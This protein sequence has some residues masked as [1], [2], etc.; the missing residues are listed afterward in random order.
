MIP[1]YQGSSRN[2]DFIPLVL[3]E[4]SVRMLADTASDYQDYQAEIAYMAGQLKSVHDDM[5]LVQIWDTLA[6]KYDGTLWTEKRMC[7]WNL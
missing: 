7:S 2:T 4:E 1:V 6:Q 3:S 5:P